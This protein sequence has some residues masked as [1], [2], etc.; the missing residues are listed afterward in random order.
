VVAGAGNKFI[1]WLLHLIPN[2][3]LL[4]AVGDSMLKR[5]AA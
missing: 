4:K 3:L 2:A 5:G 1:V